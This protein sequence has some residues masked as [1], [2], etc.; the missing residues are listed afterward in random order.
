MTEVE[1]IKSSNHYTINCG[2]YSGLPEVRFWESAHTV[3]VTMNTV[4][5]IVPHDR[6]ERRAVLIRLCDLNMF[7]TIQVI[8]W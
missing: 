4:V 6:T 8:A 1:L 5:T 7:N 2:V 3:A